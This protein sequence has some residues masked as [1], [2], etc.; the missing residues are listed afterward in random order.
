[1][2]SADDLVALAGEDCGKAPELAREILMN[3]NDLHRLR[4]ARV[5]KAVMADERRRDATCYVG[6]RQDPAAVKSVALACRRGSS[7][8]NRSI[9]AS[10]R[11]W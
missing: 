4:P 5:H 11:R 8:E 10:N 7:S 6:Q 2:P 3:E 1:M 9:S